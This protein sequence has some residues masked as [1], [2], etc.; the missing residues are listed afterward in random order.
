MGGRCSRNCARSS[1]SPQG[2]A[3]EL[4]LQA[5]EDLS[6]KDFK[7]FRHTLARGDLRGKRRI[8]WGRLEKADWMD[9]KNL[10]LDFYG[11]E[12][13]DVAIGIFE[14]IQLRHTAA[15]LQES[16]DKALGPAPLLG[17]SSPDYQRNYKKA[18]RQAYSRFKDQ[19][20]QIGD[21]VSLNTRYLKL[22]IVN[23]HR[24]EEQREHEIMAMGRRHAEI[25]KEQANSSVA[26]RDL[27]KPGPDG[28]TPKVV[29]LLGAAGV[30]KTMTARKIMLDWASDKMFAEFDYV[31]YIHCREGNLLTSQA[32]MADLISQCSRSSPLPLAEMLGQPER[33]LF[34]I[35]GFDE[36]RFS[37]DRPQSELCSQPW[38]KRSVEITLSSLFRRR[39]LPES[40]LLVTTRPAALQKL[41]KCLE[42]ERYAE[43]LGFSEAERKEYFRKFFKNT[44]QGAAAFQFVRGNETLFTMCVVP[45]VC[46][47]VCTVMKQ[48]LRRAGGLAQSPKT[49]TGIYILYLSA[50]LRSLSGRLKRG[51][52]GVLRGLCCLAADGIWK[53]KVLFEEKEV[54]GY[55]LDQRE[56]LPLLLN[57]HLFQKDIFC[58]S[59]YSFI[60]LSF[61]EFF[62][63]LFYLLEDEGEAREPPAGPTRDVKE[64]LESY[65][66]SRNYFMLTVR[67]L[68]GLLNEERRKELEEEMGCKI[69][70][71]VT[72]ELLAWLLNSQ[73][74]ALA[75]LTQETAVIREL[76]VCHCLY[77][78]QDERF[79][80]TALDPFMGVHLRGLNLNRFDQM[81]LAFSIRNFPKLESLDLGHCVFLRD[82]PEDCAGPQPARQPCREKE[83]EEGEQ[84]PIHL[85]CQAL[86]K[87]GCKLKKLRFDQCQLTGACCGALASVLSANPTLTQ[88]DLAG[89]EDLRDGGV[90]LLCEGLRR[91]ACRLQTLR[92][93]C[94][95]L[96]A[97][98]CEALAAV[99]GAV[100]SLAQLDLSDNALGD[101]GLRELCAAL[102]GPGCSVQSLWYGASGRRV[103]PRGSSRQVLSGRQ[104]G[105][106]RACGRVC[107]SAPAAP[108]RCPRAALIK[109]PDHGPGLKKQRVMLWRCRL[110]EASC[111]A[112]AAVL[113]ASPR[114]TE[115]HL[116]DNELG[117]GGAR[118]LSEGLRDAACRLQTLSFLPP[119]PPERQRAPSQPPYKQP[120]GEQA[121]E[122]LRSEGRN[123]GVGGISQGSG[124]ISPPARTPGK[125]AL[126]LAALEPARRE[127]G[128]A[129]L[130]SGSGLRLLSSGGDAEPREGAAVPGGKGA[131]G[132]E[133]G[134]GTV[135]QRGGQPRCRSG[136]DD[137]PLLRPSP[138]R[139]WRCRL[140]EASC[141][142]LAA[143]LAASPRLTELHLGGNELG[144]GGVRRLSEG[145][146]DAACRLQTLRDRLPLARAPRRVSSCRS[147]SLSRAAWTSLGSEALPGEAAVRS[148]PQLQLLHPP[149]HFRCTYVGVCSLKTTPIVFVVVRSNQG[150][151]SQGKPSPARAHLKG[152]SPPWGDYIQPQ[153]PH[154]KPGAR[155]WSASPPEAISGHA[156]DLGRVGRQHSL[157]HCRLTGACCKDLCAVLSARQSLECLDLSEN[158]LGDGGAQLLCETLGHPT[159][160]LQRLC[161]PCE[162]GE[163]FLRSYGC[164]GR[165]SPKASWD[166]GCRVARAGEHRTGSRSRVLGHAAKDEAGG[167]FIGPRAGSGDGRSTLKKAALN[168]ETLQ[169][170]AAL[171]EVKPNLDIG[172]I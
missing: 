18:I 51:M 22:V 91:G 65:G 92:L 83:Q 105:Q 39:L 55:A 164:S 36:L 60:H 94:C 87:S 57:E 123:V 134:C 147:P 26:V 79:V 95:G 163:R 116:G 3:G 162:A 84:S 17:S 167:C 114:L 118:R 66:N 112:L 59:T 136:R 69:A 119:F 35:D 152:C 117:D 165:P 99:V 115:L 49:T 29:V 129:A 158:D 63:A 120:G 24:D 82:D 149:A 77:E 6:E 108:R 45:I 125:R 146:R 110:T 40:S 98:S 20:A 155:L 122:R 9:T 10:M 100:P 130:P 148:P 52:P 139:L 11:G 156:E 71:R 21:N 30:G 157:W 113:A 140:T 111:G 96:T 58:V 137:A 161:P 169:K 128:D 50:L 2:I 12:A 8:P 89:N 68:F 150:S 121:A 132:A 32:S 81:V 27:F 73:K 67:F 127:R 80:A 75:V 5:L 151:P 62:A 107:R 76:E 53:Q 159:C 170:L 135:P 37:F 153:R 160:S 85:L 88:L 25:M 16:R 19:N 143:V 138:R 23:K 109:R 7:R 144:D 171:K 14:R 42:C 56:A 166:G 126:G 13:L 54:Q 38:E 43:I 44:E 97:A 86:E 34:V 133:G 102:A 93:G 1:G 61:Q 101:G 15:L 154:K 90:R 78:L 64:L 168:E 124:N 70:P 103:P 46:W 104:R 172:Y 41:S 28:W 131:V 31:F 48:Q 72:Q 141:G 74:T 33:L 106:R 47:I 145:L 142:A 4:L